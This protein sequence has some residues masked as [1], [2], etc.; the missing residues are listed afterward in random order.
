MSAVERVNS[1]IEQDIIGK[2]Q[3]KNVSITLD[4][5]T[6]RTNVGYANI[7]AYLREDNEILKRYSLGLDRHNETYGVSFAEVIT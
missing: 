5:W 4:D 1:M 6:A 3:S 2:S 7:N